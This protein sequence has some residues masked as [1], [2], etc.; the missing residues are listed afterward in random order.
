MLFFLN[1]LKTASLPP[2][3]HPHRGVSPAGPGEITGPLS[4][5]SRSCRKGAP[6]CRTRGGKG[7]IFPALARKPLM[8]LLVRR[9][10]FDAG[11]VVLRRIAAADRR[12]PRN[13]V[14]PESAH[15]DFQNSRCRTSRP[16]RP[17][18]R[19]GLKRC[20]PVRFGAPGSS[21]SSGYFLLGDWRPTGRNPF[22]SYY[23]F[24]GRTPLVVWQARQPPWP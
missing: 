14:S 21:L 9:A 2:A 10:G 20:Y 23:R 5:N 16:C 13:G 24:S 8:A 17:L 1:F 7:S 4:V 6:P 18:E 15:G 3:L 22:S 19:K 11:S 12:P